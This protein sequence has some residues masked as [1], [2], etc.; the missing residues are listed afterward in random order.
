MSSPRASPS[1]RQQGRNAR[2][3]RRPSLPPANP[4]AALPWSGRR[5]RSL[6]ISTL[7]QETDTSRPVPTT[8]QPL[9][10]TRDNFSL[11]PQHY[12]V[13]HD[14]RYDHT[15]AQLGVS[16]LQS[17]NRTQ[18]PL[19]S[20]SQHSASDYRPSPR[21]N[22]QEI[23]I[24]SSHNKP[25]GE[26]SSG[27]GGWGTGRGIL[28]NRDYYP[29]SYHQ[30]QFDAMAAQD[31]TFL[32]QRES[33][34]LNSLDGD[35]EQQP[36]YSMPLIIECAILGAPQQKLTLAELRIT[37]KQRF[38]YYGK[39]EEKGVRSWERTLLQ[40]LSKKERFQNIE[41]PDP[42][43]GGYW[44]INHNAA[45]ANR[46]RKRVRRTDSFLIKPSDRILDRG[47]SSPL[48][49]AAAQ[50]QSSVDLVDQEACFLLNVMEGDTILRYRRR[51]L[52]DPTSLSI[53]RAPDVGTLHRASLITHMPNMT[54]EY[55][56]TAM[57]SPFS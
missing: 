15:S 53:R 9:P 28:H 1:G 39:E 22:S 52:A 56:E 21:P 30:A 20:H 23:R 36:L 11:N 6:S 17:T 42:G 12:T 38:H 31:P 54:H 41:R 33:V 51:R 40:N 18:S 29:T 8:S 50:H 44:S 3:W 2:E 16:H 34:G 24:P 4:S 43:Q 25:P 57:S 45:P 46:A 27:S 26:T 5:H 7:L 14:E 47:V 10:H 49:T 19:S 35:L 48:N 13:R 55:G 32:Q 37:L